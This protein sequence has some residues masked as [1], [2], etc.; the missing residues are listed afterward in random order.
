MRH[1]AAVLAFTFA[2]ALA[3]LTGPV[4]ADA[5][6]R[7]AGTSLLE[8]GKEINGTCAACHGEFG[9]GGK[10]GEYP[11]IAGQ[12]VMHIE[13]Q[14]RNFRARKRVNIPMFPYTQERELPDEDIRAV[15]AYLTSIVLPTRPPEFKDSDDA[16]TRLL[17]MEKVMIIPRLDGDLAN[18]RAL[19][20]A[21]CA[22]CH[23]PRALGKGRYPMLV[24][25]YTNY[26]R[27]QMDLF[28]K[29]ERVHDDDEGKGILST[30]KD[31]DFDD[32]LAYI[33]RLQ[34]AEPTEAAK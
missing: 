31:K 8:H 1:P 26:L 25:Q 27:R 20:A 14:L 5:P 13:E 19:Y 7:A 11:R 10:K 12:R 32:L 15:A 34:D 23:G 2:F 4:L 17:A 6:A 9:Q 22:D 24:G 3:G 16:L 30:L 18:G 21:Q 33:T 28:A 29:G